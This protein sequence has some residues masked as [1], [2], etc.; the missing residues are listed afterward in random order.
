MKSIEPIRLVEKGIVV[1][2]PT[3]NPDNYK[4]IKIEIYYTESNP[5]FSWVLCDTG[6]T[7]IWEATSGVQKNGTLFVYSTYDN[8]KLGYYKIVVTSFNST[9]GLIRGETLIG[10]HTE[11]ERLVIGMPY[12][13]YEPIVLS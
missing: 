13:A 2:V 11:K 6:I 10:I 9:G 12:S 5:I 7:K 8:L 3:I 4:Y 1:Y